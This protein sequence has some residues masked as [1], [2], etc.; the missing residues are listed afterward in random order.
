MNNKRFYLN[1]YKTEK[2]IRAERINFCPEAALDSNG[3]I[4]C[5]FV[6]FTD[7]YRRSCL[8]SNIMARKIFNKVY[9]ILSTTVITIGV[10][11]VIIYLC[12]IRLYHVKSGSMGELLPVGS[13]CFVS[14]YSKYDDITEG[15]VISFSVNRD[16]MVTHR[17]ISVTEDGII[18][19]GDMN[20]APDPDYVTRDNYIGKTVFALPYIGKAL[21]FFH[22]INGLIVIAAVVLIM[23]ITGTFYKRD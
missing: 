9:E 13:V 11:L 8:C 7:D 20:N 2:N 19:Q 10:I 18:T 5:V 14:T 15:D 16:I 22:T 1:T 4:G 3:G 12:G 23:L 17:A 6:I 21:E